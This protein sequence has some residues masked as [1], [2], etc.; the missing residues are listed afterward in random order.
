MK[1]HR[2]V[3]KLLVLRQNCESKIEEYDKPKNITL[4]IDM[5]DQGKLVLHTID[6]SHAFVRDS[7]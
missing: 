1:L 3:Q 5:S 7:I 6:K 2:L 4:P